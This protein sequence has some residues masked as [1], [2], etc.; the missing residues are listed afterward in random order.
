M[1]T[2][3][4]KERLQSSSHTFSTDGE[5]IDHLLK[6]IPKKGRSALKRFVKCLREAAEGTAHDELADFIEK[7]AVESKNDKMSSSNTEPDSENKQGA[8]KGDHISI[9]ASI[10]VITRIPEDRSSA[11]MGWGSALS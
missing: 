1:L 3:H 5:K 4:E 8:G 7:S 11:G 9:L 2:R 6:I 10:C